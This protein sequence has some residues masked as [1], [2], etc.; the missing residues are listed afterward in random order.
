MNGISL[1]TVLD[2]L[3]IEPEY[4]E[5]M[6]AHWDES[7][8]TLPE[9]RLPFL[10]VD[11][12][13]ECRQFCD[14]DSELDAVLL[15]TS[16]RIEAWPD[17][18]LLIWH[19]YRR[20][21]VHTE[22]PGLEK[23]PELFDQLG[24]QGG[25][26]YMLVA[27]AMAKLVKNAHT[28]LDI[29]ES[30]TR[31]TCE[32]RSSNKSHKVGRDGRPGV[33]I[34]TLYWLRHYTAGRLFRLGRFTYMLRELPTQIWGY[35]N[36]DSGQVAL[37]MPPGVHFNED[38]YV[39]NDD[40]PSKAWIS[41]FT[42]TDS[43]VHGFAASALGMAIETPMTLNHTEWTQILGPGDTVL[44]MH[45]PAGGGMTLQ[46]CK[47]SLTQ[48]FT[49]F[50]R[51]FPECP[52]KAVYCASWIFN[53]Q[54]EERLPESNLAKFMRELYLFPILSDGKDGLFFVFYRDYDD[55][56]LAPR[57]TSLQRALIDIYTSGIGL[58]SSGM[59]FFEQDLPY[60]GQHVYRRMA[61]HQG[62]SE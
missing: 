15:D 4:R 11:F 47:Q 30:V 9:G 43:H 13:Q 8:Q 7:L 22:T 58:R 10:K 44:D 41:H 56:S 52:A 17:M 16:D 1:K 35:R 45:I 46:A 60:F 50:R 62:S 18:R 24:D 53:T 29:D 20:L 6:D 31:D 21:Y 59:L 51:T 32:L 3:P 14:L 57:K 26:F 34:R 36:R 12:I 39:V 5:A 40:D 55:W 28:K 25:I 2:R 19:C 33:L 42:Q 27:Q 54:L 38:G 49:F 48:A 23:W 37:L 61:K